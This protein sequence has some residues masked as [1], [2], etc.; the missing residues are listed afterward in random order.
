MIPENK[1]IKI[2]K[3]IKSL[4]KINDFSL[5]K[6]K[7]KKK[8]GRLIFHKKYTADDL[9]NI[10]TNLGMKKGS[11]VCIHASMMEFYNYKGTAQE[12]IDKIMEILGSEGTLI[13]PSYPYIPP[14]EKDTFIFDPHNEPTTAGFLAETFRKYPGVKRSNNVQHS[15]CAIG[16]YANYLI[17]DH[18][19]C[20]D[21]WDLNSPWSR[22]CELDALIFDMGLGNNYLSTICHCVESR[23]ANSFPYWSLFFNHIEKYRYLDNKNNVIEYYGR[24][25][26]LIRITKNRNYIKRLTHKE[27]KKN[28][29]SNLTINV[30]YSKNALDKMIDLASKGISY[31]KV[32][33]PKNYKF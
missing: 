1:I 27:H 3:R 16:K 14:N 25:G 33:S 32:P 12:L 28:K 31:Y 4:I 30:F 22:M 18:T 7:F 8:I 2:R 6:K 5:F 13:M 11:V 19:K 26:D 24:A 9:I 20:L 15:V 29:I 17:K 10:M 23:L 21:C